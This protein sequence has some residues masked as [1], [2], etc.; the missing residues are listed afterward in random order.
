MSNRSAIRKHLARLETQRAVAKRAGR[1]AQAYKA[2]KAAEAI[3]ALSTRDDRSAANALPW[4]IA[5]SDPP[6]NQ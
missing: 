6:S 2:K 5:Q 3:R 4:G 1:G